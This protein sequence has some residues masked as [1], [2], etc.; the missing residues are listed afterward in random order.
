MD[1][2]QI[3]IYFAIFAAKL[4]EVSLA[5]VRNVLI[6]RGEKLY[7]AMIG[8]VEVMIW[9]VVVSNVLA[10]LSEDPLQALIYCLAFACGNYVGVIIEGK[11]AIGTACIQVMVS[12]LEEMGA[13]NKE[14]QKPQ[15]MITEQGSEDELKLLE[16]HETIDEQ[17]AEDE[18]NILE[19]LNTAKELESKEKKEATAKPEAEEA[20]TAEKLLAID[21]QNDLKT[22]LRNRGFGVTIVEAQGYTREVHIMMIYLKRKSVPEAL[23]LI[24]THTPSALV[25]VNDVRQIRNAF[26]RK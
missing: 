26:I 25:T 16:E 1:T 24:R 12:D 15:G 17:E 22:L 13:A 11:L 10:A 4:I 14:E 20:K 9:I 7:G 18:L 3:L 19:G 21:G 8:F 6:N 23:E 2:M 5:T